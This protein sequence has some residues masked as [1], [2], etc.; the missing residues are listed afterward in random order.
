MEV[1]RCYNVAM[2]LQWLRLPEHLHQQIGD[3]FIISPNKPTY[4]VGGDDKLCF[5]LFG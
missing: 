2:I 5:P 4:C 3:R 1:T